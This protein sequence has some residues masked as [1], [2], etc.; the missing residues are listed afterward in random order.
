MVEKKPVSLEPYYRRI[1]TAVVGC[2][3]D[4][5]PNKTELDNSMLENFKKS[6]KQLFPDSEPVEFYLGRAR[7]IAS[8]EIGRALTKGPD[9]LKP[10]SGHLYRVD[11]G[12]PLKELE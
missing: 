7:D 8:E 11:V 10:R 5:A 4:V 1:I 12:G 3:L 2:L 9:R 6:K